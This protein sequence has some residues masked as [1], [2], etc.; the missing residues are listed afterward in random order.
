MAS[1][2]KVNVEGITQSVS[3]A[4]SAIETL[5]GEAEAIY[6]RLSGSFSESAGE[7]AEALR[8]QQAA[9]AQLIRVMAETTRKFVSSISFAADQLSTMDSAG[10]QQMR[11]K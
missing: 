10:A 1:D 4:I 3:A 9:E 2:I 5:Q 11:K 7:Q 8:E 6:G